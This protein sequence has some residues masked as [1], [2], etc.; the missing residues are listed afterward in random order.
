M[1]VSNS[2]NAYCRVC[3]AEFSL[4]TIFNRDMRGFCKAWRTRHERACKD[5]TP[6]QRRAWA[7]KYAG[8]DSTESSIIVDLEHPAFLD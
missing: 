7:K 8:L 3:G 6:A 2:A 5:R 1:G 4:F